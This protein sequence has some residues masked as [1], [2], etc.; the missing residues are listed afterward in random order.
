MTDGRLS[1]RSHKQAVNY[2]VDELTAING[3][4]RRMKRARGNSYMEEVKRSLHSIA[5]WIDFYGLD[6]R[7]ESIEGKWLPPA[8]DR[9][10]SVDG[11]DMARWWNLSD[12]VGRR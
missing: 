2:I 9:L 6:S 4:I 5:L 7:M 11:A 1:E 12:T 3:N 10:L 8:L